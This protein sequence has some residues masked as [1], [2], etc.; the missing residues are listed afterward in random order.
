VDGMTTLP[1]T[2]RLSAE[3]VQ[4]TQYDGFF[5][6]YPI[7]QRPNY[8]GEMIAVSATRRR[9]ILTMG[10]FF[11][12]PGSKPSGVFSFGPTHRWKS[13]EKSSICGAVL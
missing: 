12:H 4:N 10:A 1:T 11:A 3:N 2:C 8:R 6:R 7:T 5:A 9:R 13:G